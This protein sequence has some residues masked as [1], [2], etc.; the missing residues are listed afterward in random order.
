MNGGVVGV[1]GCGKARVQ[2]AAFAC[3]HLKT[4]QDPAIDKNQRVHERDQHIGSRRFN[5]RR[6]HIGRSFGLVRRAGEIQA[7][8]VSTFLHDNMITNRL[9]QLDTVIINEALGFEFS[10]R[11]FGDRRAHFLLRQL[12]QPVKGA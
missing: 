9:I 3:S 11:P 6:A 4:A 5:Q 2:Q 12:K 8:R 1:D 7:D 10:V